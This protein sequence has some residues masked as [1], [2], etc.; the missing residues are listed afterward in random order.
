MLEI[1]EKI[2]S[3]KGELEDLDLLEELAETISAAALCGLGKTAPNPVR[4][5]LRYF[6]D[7]YLAHVVDKKCP[8]NICEKLKTVVIIAEKCKGCTKCAKLCPAGAIEGVVKE[9]FT[10]DQS[11][12]TKCFACIAACPFGA[13]EEEK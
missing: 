10:I 2:V 8:V 9:P 3:G 7:E 11:K 1:M 13:I 4:S 6:R 12:C 5:T